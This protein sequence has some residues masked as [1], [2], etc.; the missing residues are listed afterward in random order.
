MEWLTFAVGLV[1][2]LGIGASVKSSDKSAASTIAVLAA[3]K[4]EMDKLANKESCY[5]EMTLEFG[6]EKNDEG[7]DDFGEVPDDPSE[8][9]RN[10]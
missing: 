5:M 8:R 7:E 6:K 2:G 10:N 3:L 1:L 4:G 9:W